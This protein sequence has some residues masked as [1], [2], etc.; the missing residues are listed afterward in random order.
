MGECDGRNALVTGASRGIG[1]VIAQHLARAGATVAVTARTL[2]P[3]PKYPGTLRETV[4]AIESAGGKAVAIK[5]D[6]SVPDDRER[7]IAE[8]EAAIGPLDILVNNAAVAFWVPTEQQTDKRYR[9]M[10]ETMVHAPFHLSMLLLPG[11]RERG[12]GWILNVSSRASFH[13]LGPPYEKIHATAGPGVYGMCK[14][15]LERFTTALAAETHGAGIAVNALSPWDVVATHGAETHDLVKYGTEPPELMGEAAVALCS[16]DPLRLT[17]RITYTQSLL[18][19][20]KRQP[21]L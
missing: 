7:L 13:P 20:L 8:A 15:A 19:E 5:A 9:L 17:G 16:G 11:M 10:F 12:R 21:R 6:L 14:A 18:A 2:E 4:E 3:D 1:A